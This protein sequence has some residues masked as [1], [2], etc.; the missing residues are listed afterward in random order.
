MAKRY[1]NWKLA[2]VLL[3]GLTVMVVTAYGL[4][5]WQRSRRAESGL[6]S[7]N[8]AYLEQRWDEAANNLGRYIAVET[9][10][11]EA[12]MKYADAQLNRRPMQN[13]HIQQAVA[14]YRNVLRIEKG[15]KDASIRLA[16]L[17]LS[18]RMPGEAELIA[19]RGVD[20][21]NDPELRGKLAQSFIGQRKFEQALQELKDIIQSN[22]EQI[23]AYSTL[24]RLIEQ[25]PDLSSQSA[26]V[27]ID[28]AVDNNPSSAM[29]YIVRANYHLFKKD[30]QSALSDLDQAQKQDMSDP[31]E[32]LALSIAFI[33][34]KDFDRAQKHL[35]ALHEIEPKNKALWLIRADLARQSGS[36]EK[37]LETAQAGLNELASDPWDFMLTATS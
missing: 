19:Q 34:A 16:D 31:E 32:Y 3:L 25:Y 27:W 8:K 2:I 37:M 26:S 22:P 4:R 30:L 7:G 10:D 13:S 20:I 24:S 15:N 29:A 28:R 33:N 1:F 35:M 21:N 9:R 18:M 23:S 14:A 6:E 11:I 5:K 12:L 36:K 17:Y